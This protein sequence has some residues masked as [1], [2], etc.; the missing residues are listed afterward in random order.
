MFLKR[1]ALMASRFNVGRVLALG[2]YNMDVLMLAALANPKDVA[3]Y[4]LAGSIA[5]PVSLPASGLAMSLFGNMARVVRLKK[6]WVLSSISISLLSAIIV[7]ALTV[8]FVALVERGT[9]Q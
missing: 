6:S 3:T 8:P 7:S 1:C 2:T 9:R 5:V 4:A